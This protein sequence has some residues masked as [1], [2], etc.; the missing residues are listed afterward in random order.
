ME[1]GNRNDMLIRLISTSIV[2]FSIGIISLQEDLALQD[3]H[4][5]RSFLMAIV[6]SRVLLVGIRDLLNVFKEKLTC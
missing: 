3:I 2:L 5:Q 6:D 1:W 4:L